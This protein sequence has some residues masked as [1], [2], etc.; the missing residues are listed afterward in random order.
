MYVCSALAQHSVDECCQ[1]GI[2]AAL[3]LCAAWSITI[4]SLASS[5]R[6]R[7]PSAKMLL[8]PLLLLLLLLL[9]RVLAVWLQHQLSS[10]DSARMCQR[11]LR[12]KG[13]RRQECMLCVC[14]CM[15]YEQQQNPTHAV[16][17]R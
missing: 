1:P 15:I 2:T 7:S 13:F 5:G 11:C 8:L 3:L 10:T 17:C 4:A 12:Y 6:C 14:D 16:A 9:L